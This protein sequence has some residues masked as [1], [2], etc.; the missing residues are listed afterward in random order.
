V[1]LPGENI[2]KAIV[3]RSILIKEI[4]CVLAH[5]KDGNYDT[6]MEEVDKVKLEEL[7]ESK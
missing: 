3:Q 2:A 7:L 6:L 1:N 4:I 5:N